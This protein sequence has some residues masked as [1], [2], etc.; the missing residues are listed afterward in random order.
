MNKLNQTQFS[1]YYEGFSKAASE[2]LGLTPGQTLDVFEK[3]A[4]E[5][6]TLFSQ[7]AAVAADNPELTG[8]LAGTIAGGAGGAMTKED[9][10]RNALIGAGTGGVAG[11]ALGHLYGKNDELSEDLT[12]TQADLETTQAGLGALDEEGVLAALARLTGNTGKAVGDAAY[13]GGK[14][15]G[16]AANTA[17]DVI[18][19]MGVNLGNFA[20]EGG[21]VNEATVNTA[22]DVLDQMGVNL[23]NA[24]YDTFAGGE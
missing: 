9:K 14:A 20:Y 17:K 23:G 21:K 13:D 6:E 8:G 12:G 18:D 2:T 22:K 24:A 11:T 10:L 19:Q 3:F 4:N 7:L 16:S 1:A 5:D 15:I